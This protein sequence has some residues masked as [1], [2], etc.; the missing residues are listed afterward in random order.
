LLHAERRAAAP[1][2]LMGVGARLQAW[3]S[4]EYLARWALSDKPAARRCCCGRTH[5]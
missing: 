1:L 3:R 4:R 2:L 5:A